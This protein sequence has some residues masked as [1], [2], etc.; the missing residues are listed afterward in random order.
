MQ[1]KALHFS[2][3]TQHGIYSPLVSFAEDSVSFTL[4]SWST[5]DRHRRTV[6]RPEGEKVKKS[7]VR[8]SLSIL[9]TRE[10]LKCLKVQV[11]WK[12]MAA[13]CLSR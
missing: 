5:F 12:F 1:C 7:Y 2:H 4:L 10:N 8:G 11:E 9:K 3:L 13:E 6:D